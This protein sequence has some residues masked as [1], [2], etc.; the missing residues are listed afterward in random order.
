LVHHSDRGI[1]YA[2][3]DYVEV[4][5][6][7]HIT[8]SMSRAANPYDNAAC[9]SF[10]KTLKYE[11]IHCQHYSTMEEL[12][13]NMEEFIDQYYNRKRLHSALGYRSPEEFE[14]LAP[15]HSAATETLSFPGHEEIYPSEGRKNG[16]GPKGDPSAAHRPDES[17]DSYSS[18]G[19]SPAEPACASPSEHDFDRQALE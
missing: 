6:I 18:A 17:P 3:R 15:Q 2:S 12:S 7:H 4:L 14:A 8:P 5:K 19:C 11:E 16:E 9:E 10:M 13:A 1:Q